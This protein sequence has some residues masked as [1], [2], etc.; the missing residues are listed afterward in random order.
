VFDEDESIYEE[1]QELKQGEEQYGQEQNKNT[2]VGRKIRKLPTKLEICALPEW[3]RFYL[4][5]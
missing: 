2:Y 3:T 5:P 4:Q 1:K